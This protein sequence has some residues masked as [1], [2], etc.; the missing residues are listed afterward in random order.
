MV[1]I[2]VIAEFMHCQ[3]TTCLRNMQIMKWMRKTL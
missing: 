2:A 3:V 1:A